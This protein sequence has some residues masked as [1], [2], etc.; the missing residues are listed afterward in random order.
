MNR[1]LVVITGDAG[2]ADYTS[3]A[4]VVTDN[5]LKV[6]RKVVKALKA[7]AKDKKWSSCNWDSRMSAE[8]Q[9]PGLLTED[10]LEQFE[11]LLPGT[12]DHPIHTITSV[13]LYEF[14][15]KRNLL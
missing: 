6:V 4:T 2:D 15:S 13:K 5:D 1:H 11:D 10:E 3:K 9:Y 8:E 7:W 12:G 14:T